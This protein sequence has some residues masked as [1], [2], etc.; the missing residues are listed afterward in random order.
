MD[1]GDPAS[2]GPALQ[3]RAVSTLCGLYTVWPR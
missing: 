3:V 2:V 1:L